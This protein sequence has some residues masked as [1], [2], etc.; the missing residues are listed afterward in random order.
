M[1]GITQIT[2]S[3][4]GWGNNYYSEGAEC[5]GAIY[6]LTLLNEIMYA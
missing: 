4:S 6:F 3:Q 2:Y 1:I 5:K